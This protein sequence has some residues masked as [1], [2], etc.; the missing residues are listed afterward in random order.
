MTEDLSRYHHPLTNL[1]PRTADWH[2]YQLTTD[3]VSFY[4]EHGYLAGIPMLNNTQL[5]S[6]R[7][8]LS[9]LVDP[10]HPGHELF[11][12]FNANESADPNRILF[13]ALGAWRI[14]PGLHDV[15]WNPAFVV[16]A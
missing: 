5:D 12:E 1:F 13:H 15:L 7:R 3:Q 8:E 2:Q 16:A 9:E 6:L 4:H 11:Y 14:T 10:S